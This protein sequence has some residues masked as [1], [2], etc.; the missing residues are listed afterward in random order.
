M[1][2]ALDRL[3]AGTPPDAPRSRGGQEHAG[4]KEKRSRWDFTAE[5]DEWMW[6]LQ[7][8]DGA[9]ITSSLRFS[10]MEA[11]VENAVLH[12]YVVWHPDRERR[13]RTQ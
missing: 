9:K 4:V 8:H 2:S 7:C 13:A 11:C 6:Q 10:T 5:G 12:G 1:G 3:L